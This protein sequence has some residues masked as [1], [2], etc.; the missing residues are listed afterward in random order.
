MIGY[1]IRRQRLDYNVQYSNGC[2]EDTNEPL[3]HF[4]GFFNLQKGLQPRSSTAVFSDYK[5]IVCVICI[6]KQH[7]E[8]LFIF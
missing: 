6:K 8:S 5:T 7:A 2:R 3:S 4:F 1:P